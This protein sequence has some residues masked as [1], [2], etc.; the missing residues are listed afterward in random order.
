MVHWM[1]ALIMVQLLL[2]EH[3]FAPYLERRNHYPVR[4]IASA[5]VCVGAAYFFPVLE[6][7]Y[8]A[9]GVFLYSTLFA[10]SICTVLL[11]YQESLWTVGFCCLAG[12]TIQ[13][14]GS[15]ADT[16]F[17]RLAHAGNFPL[18][19]LLSILL[20]FFV[21]YL[22]CW[23]A[24]RRCLRQQ[25]QLLV[26][27]R[28]F[29]VLAGVA[30]LVDVV[31]GLFPQAFVMLYDREY[32][33]HYAY[34]LVLSVYDVIA[35]TGI[36][37]IMAASLSNRHLQQELELMTRMLD[38]EKKH[39]E[40]SRDTIDIINLKCHD[41]RHQIHS[42][43]AG[44]RQVTSQA[45]QEIEQAV[46]IY[47]SVYDTGNAALDVIL[48]EKS[49]LCGKSGIR[50]SCIA[51]GQAIGFLSEE[52]IY[53]LFGNALDNAMEAVAQLSDPDRREIGLRVQATGQFLSIHVENCFDGTLT[54]RDNLPLT[55]K[56]DHNYHG[57][58]MRSMQLITEKYGGCLTTSAK[59]QVFHLNIVI[60]VPA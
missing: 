34:Q 2:A 24:F 12:Y 18:P 17:R 16:L 53:A 43:R 28:H 40:I 13:H 23:L 11:C 1:N 42:L 9:Y 20:S 45:L 4:L 39:F 21:V 15:A 52:D 6:A 56:Q 19:E 33:L 29:L 25:G 26:N 38:Q 7:D 31:L 60:P 10:L 8:V 41:L 32:D 48:T 59:G 58:G 57:F 35:C 30:F 3:M 22:L 36:L 47:D 46:D 49:L 44:R 54:F 37:C 5:V 51:D 55:T 27:N 50:L 14:L